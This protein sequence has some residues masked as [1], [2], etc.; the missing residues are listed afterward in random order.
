MSVNSYLQLLASE[1]VLTDSEKIHVSNSLNNIKKKLDD[2]FG[3]QI[4]EKKVFGSYDR[5]TI[6][7]RKADENSDIDLMVVFNNSFGYKPQTFLNK[8]KNFA[9]CYYSRSEI[10]QSSPTIVLELQHIKFEITPAFKSYD[11]YY[12]PND[13]SSW[14]KTNPDEFNDLLIKCNKNNEYKIKPVVRLLKYWNIQMNYRDIASFELEKTL[15]NDLMYAYISANTYTDYLKYGLEKIKY[16]T[17]YAKVN[18]AIDHINKA[19]D[20]E[21]KDMSYSAE[22]EVQKSFPEL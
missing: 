3:Y 5:G 16:K 18:S 19:I 7:P 14:K 2:Y 9:E 12:I 15:A 20:Y 6:L 13:Q 22:I 21:R 11:T 10:Y 4:I 1:L 8:L 17:N